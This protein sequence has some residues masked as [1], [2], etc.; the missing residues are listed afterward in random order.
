MVAQATPFKRQEP[1]HIL[2]SDQ[3][4]GARQV[5]VHS[6]E[7]QRWQ[8]YEAS[9]GR[10]A[11]QILRAQVVH[12][13]VS[14]VELPDTTGFDVVYGLKLLHRWVPFILTASQ[15]NKEVLLRALVARAFTVMQ[16][17]VEEG[18]FRSTLEH[19]MGRC[20]GEGGS[21][22]SPPGEL[23]GWDEPE[24]WPTRGDELF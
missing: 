15:L 14:A 19:L 1:W 4:E 8:P 17:P 5:L 23:S 6:L 21:T 2:I 3:D 20:Y 11:L 13:L 22:G 18:L 12:V 9:S 16:K 24:P 7:P 10:E